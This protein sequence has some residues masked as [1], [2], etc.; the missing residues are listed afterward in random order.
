MRIT[1]RYALTQQTASPNIDASHRCVFRCPQCARAKQYSQH[2][3]KRSFDLDEKEF[4]KILDYY[5]KGVTFCGQISDPIY[6]PRFVNMVKMCDEQNK[7]MRI[8]TVGSGKSDKFWDEIY[9]YGK[10]KNLWLFGI[11]GIDEKSELY[12]VG[13]NFKDAW[14][15]MCQGR[16][17]N[18]VIVWQYIIFEFNENDMDEAMKIAKNE[19]L[20]LL[21]LYPNR[22]FSW[23][24]GYLRKS[25]DFKIKKPSDKYTEE[26][27]KSQWYV[28]VT[29]ELKKWKKLYG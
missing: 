10:E 18:Q 27:A 29:D 25:V 26:I 19:N 3:I 21:F 9:S 1:D 14:K 17:N 6:H 5:E 4:Q 8:S 22:G 2:Q 12:R 13:S 24:N 11:D 20:S 7:Y 23:N 15:R 28:H 16:D